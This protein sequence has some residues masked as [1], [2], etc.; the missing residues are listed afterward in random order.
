MLVRLYVN[1]GGQSFSY[2]LLSQ[3]PG[4]N[5]YGAN[6]PADMARQTETLTF[7]IEGPADS[8]LDNM[9]FLP[10]S[11]PEPSECALIGLGAVLFG[12]CRRCKQRGRNKRAVVE[13]WQLPLRSVNFTRKAQNSSAL[14][15]SKAPR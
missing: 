15:E 10:T 12:F 2:S 11:V 14:L 5:V 8:R 4:Y 1:L 9:Q 3:G 13:L 6:I 7:D